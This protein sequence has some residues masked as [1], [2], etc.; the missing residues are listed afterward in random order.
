V[1]AVDFT[2]S[3]AERQVQLHAIME[4]GAKWAKTR[5]DEIYRSLKNT[6]ER[7]QLIRV[8]KTLHLMD[9]R[10]EMLELFARAA[11]GVNSNTNFPT[12]FPTKGPTAAPSAT[13][14]KA[15]TAVPTEAPSAAPTTSPTYTCGSK[16]LD[17]VNMKTWGELPD[18]NEGTGLGQADVA[19]ACK[20]DATEGDAI[21]AQNTKSVSTGAYT[22]TFGST[23]DTNLNITKQEILPNSMDSDTYKLGIKAHQP[24]DAARYFERASSVDNR[25]VESVPDLVRQ[26]ATNLDGYCK[27]EQKISKMA[28]VPTGTTK[29]YM[30][31]YAKETGDMDPIK[32]PGRSTAF[33][34][35]LRDD[36]D[37]VRG[38]ARFCTDASVTKVCDQ[39]EELVHHKDDYGDSY[40]WLSFYRRDGNKDSIRQT[41]SAVKQ[42][43]VPSDKRYLQT[44]IL[45]RNA[46]ANT[47][48]WIQK[49]EIY[50]ASACGIL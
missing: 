43:V 49:L 31:L 20:F 39:W 2:T 19:A 12:S 47:L 6:K 17:I 3:E 7:E 5:L 41:G 4:K 21:Y 28:A 27:W 8:R 36:Y 42:V 24:S 35:D 22:I 10:E 32:Y 48:E 33:Y 16:I 44:R 29:V 13:P 26:A 37:R 15:P 38:F 30:R 14:T 23:G 46:K 9:S 11:A 18:G 25:Y 50:D 34:K 40:T 45:T 1:S